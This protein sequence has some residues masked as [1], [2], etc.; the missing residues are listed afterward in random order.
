MIL[1]FF[2]V[3]T[4]IRH[5][6]KCRIPVS[7]AVNYSVYLQYS[8]HCVDVRIGCA[9]DAD[10]FV[11]IHRIDDIAVSH[12]Q[13]DMSAVPV[14]DHIARL[15]VVVAHAISRIYLFRSRPRNT[16]AEMRVHRLGKSGTV[17]AFR[18]ACPAPDIRIPDKPAGVINDILS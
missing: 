17:R 10:P 11:R 2:Y 14:E 15:R 6:L 8:P 16:D 1:M 9:A 12:I 13:P 18:K 5:I 7:F 3:E 4:G